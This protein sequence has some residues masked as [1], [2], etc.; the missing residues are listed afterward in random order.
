M[1][2]KL[3]SA[4][5]A[6]LALTAVAAQGATPAANYTD[7]WWNASESG[8][9]LSWAQH[10]ASGQA[11]VVWYTYDPREPDPSTTDA[12]DYKPLWIVMP[13]GTW[14]SPTTITV[15]VYV[16][17]GTPYSQ[18]WNS[19]NYVIQQVGTFSFSFADSSNGMFAYS[20]APPA[21][22]ASTNPAYGLPAFS[23]VKNI[24]RLAF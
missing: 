3:L 17:G 8:W 21:G 10:T 24:T 4:C 9:G 5:L 19:A 2:R 22:L 12:A 23:G 15:T 14:T 18:A 11:F 20:I 6:S 1:T 7:M 13:G 16:T